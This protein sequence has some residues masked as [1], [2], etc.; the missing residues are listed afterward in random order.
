MRV[1]EVTY[2]MKRVTAQYE[3]DTARV[4]YALEEGDNPHAALEKA[5]HL[6]DEALTT[7]RDAALTSK[8]KAKMA[9][10]EGRAALE[11][12]LRCR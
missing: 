6:C 9:T 3:N 5:R 4:T 12:F 8:L 1:T 7:G 2:E 10:A 11:A